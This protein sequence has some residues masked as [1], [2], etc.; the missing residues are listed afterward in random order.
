MLNSPRDTS[1]SVQDDIINKFLALRN[2]SV[3][4]RYLRKTEIIAKSLYDQDGESKD[5][6]ERI[7][8]INVRQYFI[9]NKGTTNVGIIQE[10]KVLRKY[11]ELVEEKKGKKTEKKYVEKEK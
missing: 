3:N 1:K 5:I 4:F 6:L 8:G 2:K 7:Y 11:K 10:K 9:T